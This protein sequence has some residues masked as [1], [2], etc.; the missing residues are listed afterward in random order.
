MRNT[1]NDTVPESDPSH[2]PIEVMQR[3]FRRDI[4]EA[5]KVYRMHG[6]KM[7][8]AGPDGVIREVDPQEVIDKVDAV[9]GPPAPRKAG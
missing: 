2:T 8:G 9:D 6:V 1:H 5:A 7:V 4:R 3:G